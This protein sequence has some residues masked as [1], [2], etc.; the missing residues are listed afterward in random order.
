[1]PLYNNS[2]TVSAA[3]DSLLAQTVRDVRIVASDDCSSDDTGSICK[4]YASRDSRI[5]YVRQPTNLGYRNFKFVLD[6]AETV[7][8]MWAAGDDRWAPTFIEE[9]LRALRSD[10]ALVGSV[11]KV[12]FEQ[13][14]KPVKLSGGT[15]PLLGGIKDN[16][17]KFLS[18][19]SDNS[20]MYGLFRTEHLRRSFPSQSFHA[21]DWAL[22]AATL[23]HGK[24]NELPKVL[25]FRDWTL[26]ARYSD[27]V[28]KDH[29]RVLQR[30]FPVMQMT[31]WL[32]FEAK[33]PLTWPIAGALIALNIDKHYEYSERFHPRY[34]RFTAKLQKLW[35]Q[36][37]RWRLRT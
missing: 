33:I 17:A 35:R 15:Y 36:Y 18:D 2:A 16:L 32:I 23:L 28:R 8:F 31:R 14:G 27:L 24:H 26:P 5:S 37:V 13:D 12:R 10:S 29:S 20:R 7:F 34:S 9:N 25:M 4:A 21:Y 19:P 22:S 6:K 3:L 11:S 1:M 30:L